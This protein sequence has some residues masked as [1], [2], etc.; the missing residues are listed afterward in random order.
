MS[1]STKEAF[2][3]WFCSDLLFKNGVGKEIDFLS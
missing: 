2:S 1:K 3:R